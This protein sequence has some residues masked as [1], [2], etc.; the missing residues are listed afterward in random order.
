M[1]EFAEVESQRA[2]LSPTLYFLAGPA[3]KTPQMDA[4][5]V[6]FRARRFRETG[7]GNSYDSVSFETDSPADQ[8]FT[9]AH[10]LGRFMKATLDQCQKFIAAY[11]R[12]RFNGANISQ[13]RHRSR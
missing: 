9:P 7:G 8:L 3:C 13:S 5:G 10:V 6:C 1:S 4:I 2:L 12:L 11:R